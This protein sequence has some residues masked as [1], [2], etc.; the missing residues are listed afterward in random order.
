MFK[1]KITAEKVYA[2]DQAGAEYSL[3]FLS[4][5]ELLS[6]AKRKYVVENEKNPIV[7]KSYLIDL[8]DTVNNPNQY[9]LSRKHYVKLEYN[10]RVR[11]PTTRKRNLAMKILEDHLKKTKNNPHL[12]IGYYGPDNPISAG[13]L[14]AICRYEDPNDTLRIYDQIRL[15]KHMAARDWE[16]Q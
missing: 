16:S 15:A 9:R 10:E 13:Y 12:Y 2:V 11:E 14:D 1:L 4:K 6:I 3:E 8:L 7:V 5:R